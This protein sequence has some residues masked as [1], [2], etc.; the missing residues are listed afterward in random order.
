MI[1]P[2]CGKGELQ[3]L[4]GT[5]LKICPLCSSKLISP[6]QEATPVTT[7]ERHAFLKRVT[8]EAYT[9]EDRDLFACSFLVFAL[10]DPRAKALV[11]AN[12]PVGKIL[13]FY[14]DRAFIDPD[15]S[16]Q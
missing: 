5:V 4:T 3:E 2:N 16:K 6:A 1:C 13:D 11:E 7:S 14:K 8:S 12:T 9:E 15:T 10:F